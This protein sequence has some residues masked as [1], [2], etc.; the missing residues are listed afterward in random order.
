[1]RRSLGRSLSGEIEDAATMQAMGGFALGGCGRRSAS[2]QALPAF[3]A[4]RVAARPAVQ[5]LF[6]SLAGAGFGEPQQ[7][8]EQYEARTSAAE[9]ALRELL[10]AG[11]AAGGCDARWCA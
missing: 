7:F 6:G 4:S 11:A 3:L 10:P 2:D 8:L 9:T 1:M 5:L